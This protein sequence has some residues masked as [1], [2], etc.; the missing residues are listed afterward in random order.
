MDRAVASEIRLTIEGARVE[1]AA[2]Y[3]LNKQAMRGVFHGALIEG[4]RPDIRLQKRLNKE[5]GRIVT[6]AGMVE[7]DLSRQTVSQVKTLAGSLV[8]NDEI[9]DRLMEYQ[10]KVGQQL[11]RDAREVGELFRRTQLSMTST[12]VDRDQTLRAALNRITTKQVF[13]YV[14]AQGRLWES[15]RYLVLLSAQFYYGLANDLSIADKISQGQMVGE[16]NRPGH[17]TDGMKFNLTEWPDI[18]GEIAHPQSKTIV[19]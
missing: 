17:K 14:D 5:L 13:G 18:R 2:R 16:V 19:T 1:M 9:E 7:I 6:T 11:K 4:I 10:K 15:D 12:F 8:A 3:S